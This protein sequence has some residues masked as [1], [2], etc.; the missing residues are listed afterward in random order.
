ML[1]YCIGLAIHRHAI[2]KFLHN[3]VKFK[4]SMLMYGK[5]NTIIP[6]TKILV[7]FILERREVMKKCL[8]CYYFCLW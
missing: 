8:S 4:N 7:I 2:F 1:Q 3:T 5:T 6:M